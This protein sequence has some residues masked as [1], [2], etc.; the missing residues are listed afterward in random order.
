MK[1]DADFTHLPENLNPRLRE[2]LRR[3]LAKNRKDRWYAAGDIRVEMSSIIAEPQRLET[4][5]EEMKPRFW[6][7]AL[8]AALTGLV[9][10]AIAGAFMWQMAAFVSGSHHPFFL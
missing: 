8:P 10:A 9:V 3:C 2:L 7:R 4:Q 1:I 6:N 5:P